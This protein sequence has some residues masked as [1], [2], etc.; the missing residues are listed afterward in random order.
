MIGRWRVSS[1]FS[2]WALSGHVDGLAAASSWECVIVCFY[3]EK[4]E[5]KEKIKKIK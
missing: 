5:E 4:Q 1:S 2:F 3:E